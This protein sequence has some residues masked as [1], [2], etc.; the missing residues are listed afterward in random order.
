MKIRF[1]PN[2]ALTILELERMRRVVT[3]ARL[4]DQLAL[5]VEE[6]EPGHMVPHIIINH[7]AL[8]LHTL[9]DASNLHRFLMLVGQVRALA[10]AELK[11]EAPFVVVD[12][13]QM[14]FI[15]LVLHFG[16]AEVSLGVLREQV[17]RCP[18][19]QFAILR[20]LLNVKLFLLL[21]HRLVL[22]SVDRQYLVDT[23]L[24]F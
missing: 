6:M 17:G 2:N 20:S 9:R 24:H 3:C 16:H 15:A 4:Q 19:N 11:V 13:D 22:H 1:D 5:S 8:D 10:I 14:N 18:C 21:R 7:H 12:R 23:T